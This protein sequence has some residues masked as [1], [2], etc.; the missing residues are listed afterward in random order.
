[1]ENIL[2]QFTLLR[3]NLCDYRPGTDWCGPASAAPLRPPDSSTVRSRVCAGV[4]D[5]RDSHLSIGRES[6]RSPSS[7]GQSTEHHPSHAQGVH[8]VGDGP[9]RVGG[10]ALQVFR[11]VQRL[12]LCHP[13]LAP[14][15]CGGAAATLGAAVVPSLG[16]GAA[17]PTPPRLQRHA[18]GMPPRSPLKDWGAPI[19]ATSAKRRFRTDV[20][21]APRPRPAT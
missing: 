13:Q 8:R 21:A 19:V 10:R 15:S 12:M 18:G 5:G 2:D 3:T 11:L 9:A 14:M 6:P 17:R 1:M 20:V 4:V 7:I 16:R